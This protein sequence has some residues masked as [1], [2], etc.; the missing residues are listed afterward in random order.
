[1]STAHA[2]HSETARAT[3]QECFDAIT[4]FESYA[5]WA[6]GVKTCRVLER[7]DQGRGSLIEMVLDLRLRTIRYV[8]RYGYDEPAH[9]WWKS[10]D[11][12]V[13]LI[14]GD[15]RFEDQGDGTT[16]MTYSVEVDPGM[17]VPGPVKSMLAGVTVKNAVRDLKRRV[18]SR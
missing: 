4:E 7:D 16:R 1:M 6:S 9:L 3:V 17:F 10:V 2:S 13:K 8:L 15:Y 12:D 5:E 18:E 14:D 11:G